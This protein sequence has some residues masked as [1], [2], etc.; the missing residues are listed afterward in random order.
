MGRNR[1]DIE[2]QIAALQAELDAA[3]DDEQVEIKVQ[4]GDHTVTLRGTKALAF[5]RKM[6]I[7][8]DEATAGDDDAQVDD[9]DPGAG[10]PKVKSGAGAKFFGK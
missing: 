8:E 2:G 6:G 10:E 9:V 4:K 3:A 7:E 5:L 1:K